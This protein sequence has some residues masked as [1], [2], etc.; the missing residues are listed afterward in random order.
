MK[1]RTALPALAVCAVCL[2]LAPLTGCSSGGT[3]HEP[4]S[5]KG[6]KAAGVPGAPSES[7]A[8]ASGKGSKD[9]E[10]ING[11]G[12]RDLVIPAGAGGDQQNPGGDGRIAVVYGSAKGLDPSTRAVYGRRDLGLPEA[13]E[14]AGEPDAVPAEGVVHADLD[15]DGFPDFITTVEGKRADDG[16]VSAPATVPYV[17]WGGPKGP[18]AGAE[19]APVRLPRSASKLGVESVVSGDFDGDGHHDLASLAQNESSMVLLYGPFE[20]S[21]APSRTDTDLPWSDGELIADDIDPSGKPRATSLLLHGVSD[22][23]QSGNTLYTAHRA[24]GLSKNGK[25]L[26]SG[27]AH[28]FGDFDG[29][30]LRDVAVGDDGSRN[31]EPGYE[32]EA[33]DVDGSLAVYPGDGGEP[34]THRLPE[35]SK[36]PGNDFGPGPFAA[37]DP[38][39]DGRDGILVATYEGATLIDGDERTTVLR[40][41]P[42][43]ADGEKTPA[44]WR[45]ARPAGAADFDGD[46]KDELILHWAPGILFG[47]YGEHP[48]HWWITNGTTS[49][50][51]TSFNT[52]GFAR[53]A[54]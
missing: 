21:G 40:E 10:D 22:G 37:A 5:S 49:R 15:G 2:V 30:E 27:N 54:S 34:I 48:T 31:D 14:G 52:T 36:E 17:T 44:K 24:S 38:D 11:D 9:P 13:G 12:H 43:K 41:G 7:R 50:D 35:A 42:A 53:R 51:Q 18:E 6:T 20:R 23:E 45:H 47:L 33:P 28:T 19:A 26:R 1:S 16:H 3:D 32:T 25:R 8:P 29:D 39:G 46:G 4:S